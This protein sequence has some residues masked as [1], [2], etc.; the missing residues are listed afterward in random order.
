[1]FDEKRNA[2]DIRLALAWQKGEKEAGDLL[3]SR[4][5]P[6][7]SREAK[8]SFHSLAKEDLRQDLILYFLEGISRYDPRKNPSFAGYAVRLIR[9]GKLHS[10]RDWE[11]YE[12][13]EELTLENQAEE[14]FEERFDGDDDFLKEAARVAGLT[15][16]QY[17]V[18]YWWMKGESPGEIRARTGQALSVISRKQKRIR[19]RCK[20]HEG[21]LR[22]LVLGD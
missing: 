7:I 10:L 6:L 14:A 17:P 18:F 1:M 3:L 15:E 5:A 8:T 4:Y 13:K 20:Q 16:Q 22:K 21:E 9:W 12:T 11:D 19:E 2:D